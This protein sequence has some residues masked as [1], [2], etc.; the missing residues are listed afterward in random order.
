MSVVLNLGGFLGETQTRPQTRRRERDGRGRLS[1][2][3]GGRCNKPGNSLVLGKTRRSL[4]HL[5]ESQQLM[6]RPRWASVMF[7]VQMVPTTPYSLKAVSVHWLW[8]WGWWAE[9]TFQGQRRGEEPLIAG[10]S[11]RVNWQFCLLHNLPNT[12]T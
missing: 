6:R 11:L 8:L 9:S 12:R 3:V 4:R 1:R 5:P 7:T 2:P 10:S